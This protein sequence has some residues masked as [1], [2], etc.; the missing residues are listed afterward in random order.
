MRRRRVYKYHPNKMIIIL[1]LFFVLFIG[2][3]YSL[4][5][6]SLDIFGNITVKKHSNYL[7]DVLKDAAEE[8]TY[9]R[10]YTGEHQDSMAGV[11]SRKIYHWYAPS[12]AAG[13][14]LAIAIQDKNNVLFAG[15]C[16]QMIR[17]TDTGGVKMIYN[18]EAENNQCLNTRGNHIGYA[19]R[20]SHTLNTTYY[21]GTSY[22]YDK[23]NNVFSLDG[24]VTTGNI[25]LGEYTCKSTSS[26]GTCSTLYLVDALISGT[27]YYVISLNGNSHY[28]QFGTLQFNKSNSSPSYV[29]YMY[30]TIYPYNS[31]TMT[32][33]ETMLSSSSLATTYWY[34]NSA[35]WGTPTA[36]KY[37]LDNPYQVSDTTDYPNLV[38]EYT[39]RN[40]T[41]TYTSTT[42]QY[43]AAVINTTYYYIQLGNETGTT[44]DLSFYNYTYTYGES[45]TDNGNGTYT[46]NSPTT[47]NRS[48]WY[49]S[50]SSVGAGKYVCKN[51][52][53]DTC[54]DLWYTTATSNTDMTYIKVANNYKYAKSFSWDGSKYVLDNDT[55]T[56]FWNINDNT[57]KTSLNNA[58]Y[59]CWNETGECTTIS[60]I[61]Y[62]SG[63]NY[64]GSKTYSS[65]YINISNGKSVEDAKNEMLYNDNVNT[66][67]STIKSG[68]DAWYKQYLSD[69]SDY[70]EDTI[71]CNDRSQR[72]AST[73]GWTPD[74]G[75]LS[76]HMLFYGASD[77]SCPNDTD[78]FS[79]SNN[80]A[81]LTYKVGLMSY[82]EMQLLNNSNARETGQDYWLASP[83]YFDNYD[84]YEWYMSSV[85]YMGSYHVYS[86][87]GVRPAVSLISGIRYS[88]GDGSM[89][90][91]YIVYT[92]TD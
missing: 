44:H 21:Y 62:L 16:W 79:V 4:F 28:S 36:N 86:A 35:T 45:F 30:N 73:N 37:N 18:G 88:T 33:R 69:Y 46:I 63:P 84:A 91:P 6:T 48:D 12:T 59:T 47:V 32:S 8:G 87:L 11:G 26:S 78:K 39:F 53:N 82:R 14:T 10:E 15:Q 61:Y 92:R 75:S 40:A 68:V 29:G 58:H 83:N 50:Y 9:A 54:S 27:D 85:G 80:K 38:G 74:G 5:S 31:K 90:N 65:Y 51:A 7:Y 66:T 89:A 17:T 56:S 64:S 49:T 60:Y 22:T 52:V 19:S 77:L 55:S 43:I 2:M 57:N 3:G 42:V 76:T 13:G 81:Q 41:Q 25:N 20:T 34:A 1:L 23:T 67:N 70:L 24:T 71:F 72:N